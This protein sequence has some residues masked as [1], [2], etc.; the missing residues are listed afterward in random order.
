MPSGILTNIG[1]ET[2]SAG[3]F[4]LINFKRNFRRMRL[5]MESHSPPEL[6]AVDLSKKFLYKLLLSDHPENVSRF[7]ETVHCLVWTGND[8]LCQIQ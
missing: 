6:N 5:I 4:T 2:Y 3:D 7:P 8:F 1:G